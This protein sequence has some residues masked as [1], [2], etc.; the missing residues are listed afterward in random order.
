MTDQ[1]SEPVDERSADTTADIKA[2][3]VMFGALLLMAVHL[4]SGFTFDF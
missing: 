1:N 3:V 2:I 4:V